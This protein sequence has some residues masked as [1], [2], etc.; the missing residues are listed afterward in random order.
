MEPFETTEERVDRSN[1]RQ[2]VVI[3]KFSILIYY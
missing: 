3:M 2:F 1:L